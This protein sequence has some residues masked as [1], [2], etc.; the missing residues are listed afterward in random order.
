MG[1]Q[2]AMKRGAEFPYDGGTEFWDSDASNPPAAK[3]KAHATARGILADLSDRRGVR[4]VLDDVDHDV[5]AELTESL[6][7]IIRHGMAQ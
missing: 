1:A 4:H 3:D 5:R 2:E 6:A 7:E